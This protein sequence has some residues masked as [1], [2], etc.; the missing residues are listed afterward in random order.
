M[1]A[2]KVPPKAAGLM[3]RDVYGWFAR[4]ERGI[5][6]L[7]PKGRGALETYADVIESLAAPAEEARAQPGV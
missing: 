2:A 7:S 4:V 5:Y 3:Y 1:L 6:E